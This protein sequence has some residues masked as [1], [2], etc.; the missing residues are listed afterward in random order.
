MKYLGAGY[1]AKES[2]S[3]PSRNPLILANRRAVSRWVEASWPSRGMVDERKCVT[4]RPRGGGARWVA[5]I[6][7]VHLDWAGIGT[8]QLCPSPSAIDVGAFRRRHQTPSETFQ[9]RIEPC[10][11][12]PDLID[13]S[14][15]SGSWMGSA[16]TRALH[17]PGIGADEALHSCS[18][19]FELLSSLFLVFNL[20]QARPGWGL[21]VDFCGKRSHDS[22][23]DFVVFFLRD[24]VL[25]AQIHPFL[26]L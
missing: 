19:L 11:P 15:D 24:L 7:V 12:V 3:P 1:L 26:R 18:N 17:R 9:E 21:A 6:S 22:G 5:C 23:E 16:A 14:F 4:T 10:A 2:N 13:H 20:L 8:R 25:A